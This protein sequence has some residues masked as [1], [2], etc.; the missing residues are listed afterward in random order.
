MMGSG[1]LLLLLHCRAICIEPSNIEP[2]YLYRTIEPLSRHH[3]IVCLLPWMFH[4][5]A[6]KAAGD[7]AQRLGHRLTFHPSEYCKIAGERAE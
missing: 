6:L 2:V 3:H 7:A 1:E 4:C 5:Q